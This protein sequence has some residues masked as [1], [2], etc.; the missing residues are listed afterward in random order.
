MANDLNDLIIKKSNT[1][2]RAELGPIK[3]SEYRMILFALSKVSVQQNNLTVKLNLKEFCEILGINPDG[4]YTAFKR[5]IKLLTSKTILLE[6]DSSTKESPD[7]SVYPWFS[8]SHY[9]RGEISLEFNHHLAKY[10][11]DLTEN[12]TKY[13]LDNAFKLSGFYSVRLY[14]ICK[15]YQ[16]IGVVKFEWEEFRKIIGA[17]QKA[18]KAKREFRKKINEGITEINQNTDV[19]VEF[20]ELKKGRSETY[21]ILKIGKGKVQKN[22]MSKEKII[23]AIQTEIFDLTGCFFKAKFMNSRHR[24]VLLAVLHKIKETN[25]NFV[26]TSPESFFERMIKDTEALYDQNFLIKIKD[27]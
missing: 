5:T 22:N 24:V 7:F 23:N 13:F 8:K 20:E 1:L 2:N 4:A 11:F 17:T 6:S 15:Q 19:N 3:L 12:Y 26:I 9:S 27:F 16:F 14:E 21:I 18:Y 10:I 25:F